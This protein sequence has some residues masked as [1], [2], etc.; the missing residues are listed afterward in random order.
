MRRPIAAVAVAALILAAVTVAGFGI[1]AC[2]SS[3]DSATTTQA[4]DAGAPGDG[5][6]PDMSA[7]FT[8]ALD[9]LVQDGT[10]TR[11]QESAVIDAL[12]SS[13][14]GRG[15]GQ[16]GQMPSPGATPPGGQM[17]SDGATPPGGAQGSMPDP[18]E[19]FGA[20][21]DTLVSDGTITSA[22]ETAIAEALSSAM[23]QGGPGGQ[24]STTQTGTAGSTSATS[25]TQTW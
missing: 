17:P 24:Q 8:Q 2:G 3:S 9:P 7:L 18:S 1:A 25:T 22:Q 16:G 12:A 10:I 23:Q 13:M 6:A 14:P 21:L 11:D 19:M 20:A 15:G 5:Q 4:A